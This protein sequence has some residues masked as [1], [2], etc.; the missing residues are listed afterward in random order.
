MAKKC[1]SCGGSMKKMA[2][3]GS[4]VEMGI[5]GI[6]NAGRT[7]QLGFRK[8]GSVKPKARL[9]MS[10]QPP[11]T[12]TNKP[13][14]TTNPKPPTTSTSHKPVPGT[15]RGP[16]P[17]LKPSNGTST[18]TPKPKPNFKGSKPTLTLKT[19]KAGGAVKATKFA[20]LAPPYDKATAADRIAG[21]KKNARKRK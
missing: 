6:P 9:G 21:A 8:G 15:Y 17:T 1:M 7:D 11:V 16:A 13:P 19:S 3:G 18:P 5:Y 20:A 4:N 2:K 10:V 14:K 12:G